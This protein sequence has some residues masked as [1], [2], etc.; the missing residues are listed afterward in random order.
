MFHGLHCKS[1]MLLLQFQTP[2]RLMQQPPLGSG[3][4][5]VVAQCPLVSSAHVTPSVHVD[6]PGSQWQAAW[7][8]PSVQLVGKI[9]P[10]QQQQD[11]VGAPVVVV[12]LLV[13]VVVVVLVV[14]VVVV[15]VV[16][17]PSS[18]AVNATSQ[19]P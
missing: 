3:V 13:V 16:V 11:P 19:S 14:V 4:V 18:H 6:D 9:P 12:V 1:V 10:Y 5:V 2:Y 7:I 17:V 8:T 15:L